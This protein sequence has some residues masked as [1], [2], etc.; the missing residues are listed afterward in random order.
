MKNVI[1]NY[2]SPRGKM[3]LDNGLI[4]SNTIVKTINSGTPVNIEE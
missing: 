1:E 3:L 2:E 4:Y